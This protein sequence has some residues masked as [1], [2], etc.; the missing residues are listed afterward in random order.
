MQCGLPDGRTDT[1]LEKR[2]RIPVKE[3]VPG[4]DLLGLE[5][6][7]RGGCPGA[8]VEQGSQRDR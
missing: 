4:L 5:G 3:G 6:D 2:G 8:V 7:V 1:K